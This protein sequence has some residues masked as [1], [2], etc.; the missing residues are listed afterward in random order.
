MNKVTILL[1]D[2]H[3]V[4][5]ESIRKLLEERED[6][7]VV[8]EAGDGESAVE[9]AKKLRPRIVIMDIA[10]PRLNGIEATRRI[11]VESPDS[12]ILILSAYDYNQY[13]FALLEAGAKGY[14]LKDVNC[15]ELIR[16]IYSV[17][18]GEPVLCPSVAAKVM[19]R[20]RRGSSSEEIGRASCWE[21]V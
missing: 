21:R 20:F 8:G 11:R 4:V 3:A 18:K 15:Q 1:A 5:R 9:L 19:Q 12:N 16:S 17:N 7:V 13:V 2:D 14:L 6:F 10:M